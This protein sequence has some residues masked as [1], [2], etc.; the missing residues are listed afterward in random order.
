LR[1][2][3]R[4]EER[5]SI[6]LCTRHLNEVNEERKTCLLT[7]GRQFPHS[8]LVMEAL[9]FRPRRHL[10]ADRFPETLNSADLHVNTVM[11]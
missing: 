6:P 2:P 1:R 11:F 10:F 5:R 9:T 4:L 7:P 8:N 3:S